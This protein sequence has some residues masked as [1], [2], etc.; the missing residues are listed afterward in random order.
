MNERHKRPYSIDKNVITTIFLALIALLNA[1]PRTLA[2]STACQFIG[3][4][5]S[6]R[7]VVAE[8]NVIGL[9]VTICASPSIGRTVVS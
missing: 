3:Q 9:K 7:I 5:L 8:T 4:K 1:S 2:Q 6:I